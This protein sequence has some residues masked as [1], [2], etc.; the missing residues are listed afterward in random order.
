MRGGRRHCGRMWLFGRM[1]GEL[2]TV[3]FG[4][5]RLTSLRPGLGK[6]ARRRMEAAGRRG[7]AL[8]G[9]AL[10]SKSLGSKGLSQNN[11]IGRKESRD[12]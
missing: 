12:G 8:R 11:R 1:G 3:S 4:G 2:P 5:L 9:A 6:A 10:R 7:T